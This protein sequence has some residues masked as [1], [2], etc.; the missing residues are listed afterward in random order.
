[1]PDT[2]SDVHRARE[3]TGVTPF[4]LDT[5]VT[6]SV[7][8]GV[9]VVML[10]RPEQ[11]NALTGTMIECL[12]AAYR[13]CDD[14][15]QVRAVVLTGAGRVFCAGADM[16]PSANTFKATEAGST[17]SPV[18]LPAWEVRKPVIAAINGPAVGIGPTL[19]TQCDIRYGADAELAIPQVWRGT[20]GDAGSH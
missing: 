20:L 10:N 6:L 11:L 19:A 14:Q 8:D 7:D 2:G 12:S 13:W 9:A 16:T 1:M 17:A 18:R 15:D 3:G 4:A 5:V